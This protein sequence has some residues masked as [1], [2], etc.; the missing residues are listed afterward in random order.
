MTPSPPHLPTPW[1]RRRALAMALLPGGWLL[2]PR[3]AR[4]QIPDLNEAIN[5]AGR[6]RMLS[7]RMSLAWL[8]IGQGIDTARAQRVLDESMALFE[9]QLAELKAFAPNA[10]IRATYATLGPVW[11]EYKAALTGNPPGQAGGPAVVALG[12][13]V[14]AVAHQGTVQLEKHSGKSVGRLVNMAG[15]QRMLSQ[16]LAKLYFMQGWTPESATQDLETARTEFVAALKT[17]RE[18]PEA[19]PAIRQ[20]LVLAEQQWL[21]FDNALKRRESPQNPAHDPGHNPA[22]YATDVFRSSDNILQVMERV[23]GLYA[24]LPS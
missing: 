9:R 13:R 24:R 14:L 8:A 19:T 20:E 21:F 16:L 7:Q 5:K 17:L 3:H 2:G 6:Q 1:L 11:G 12:S 4:A 18:A 22:R 10:E 23:T 15:R